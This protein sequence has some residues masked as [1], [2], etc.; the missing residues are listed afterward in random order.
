MLDINKIGTQIYNLRKNS[1]YSQE[2]LADLLRISPQAISKW[3]NG[4]SLPD[5]YLLPLLAQIFDCTIDEIIIPEFSLEERSEKTTSVFE[6]QA[7]LIASH[8]IDKIADNNQKRNYNGLSDDEIADIVQKSYFIKEFTIQ[9]EKE[10]RA[11]GKISTKINIVS[12]QIKLNMVELIY[13][14]RTDEFNNYIF[15]NGNI[16]GI[17]KIYH[18]DYNKKLI[19]LDDLSDN[20]FRGYDFNEDNENGIIIRNSYSKILKEAANLHAAFWGDKRSLN[21]PPH[22][23]TKEHVLSWIYDA[24]EKPFKKYLK[25]E[26][27]GKIPNV[28]EGEFSGKPFRFENR[29]TAA[30]LDYFRESLN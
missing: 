27:N 24:I 3:E 4:H 8:V 10:S 2:K 15:L 16:N 20:Y 14:K 13:H 6:K 18:I 11:D 21:M 26:E 12:P 25:D 30:E 22:F 19:L 5:T 23:E 29:I 7:E 9:R 1:G 17:P 28:W